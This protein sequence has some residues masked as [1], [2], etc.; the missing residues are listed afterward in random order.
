M[1]ENIFT[2]RKPKHFEGLIQYFAIISDLLEVKPDDSFLLYHLK[3]GT[4]IWSGSLN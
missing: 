3:F 2:C 1:A 4:L